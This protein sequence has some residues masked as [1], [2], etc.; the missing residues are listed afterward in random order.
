M[1]ALFSIAVVLAAL[2]FV[3]V[4]AE[5]EMIITPF[6]LRPAHCHQIVP[7]GAMIKVRE[8][9]LDAH[10]LNGTVLSFP[11]KQDCIDFQAKE[12]IKRAKARQANPH[13][14]FWQDGWL[15]NAGY[16][17]PNEVMT[18][19]G[20]YT[21][22]NNPAVDSSQVLFYFIGTENLSQGQL[23]IL[24]PV[25][26]WGNG[27]NGWSM[28]SWNCCPQGQTI[29]S[30]S[31]DGLNAGDTAFGL[32]DFSSPTNWTVTSTWKGETVKLSVSAAGRDFNWC[33]V[34]LETYTVRNCN[35]FA[36]GPM[37]FSNMQ[38]TDQTGTV[39]PNWQPWSEPTECNGQLTVQSPSTIIIQHT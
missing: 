37:T 32:I 2:F 30:E 14:G 13:K 24:Q 31:L 21:V 8:D 36:T 12:W 18:F 19:S 15:D 6:G 29:E 39:T 20:T 25:L 7:S 4:Y 3:A 9:R 22:P 38:I 11:M 16:Y 27:Y 35:E 5:T 23:S 17:P 10:L 34:T 26:T 33:D 28:A 1:K